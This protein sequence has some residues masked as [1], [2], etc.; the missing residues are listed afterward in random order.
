M[1]A[2]QFRCLDATGQFGKASGEV[3]GANGRIAKLCA[4]FNRP[5]GGIEG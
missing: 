4:A 5:F 3:L 2:R 1:P